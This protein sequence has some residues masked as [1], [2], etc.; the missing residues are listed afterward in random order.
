MSYTITTTLSEELY[1]FLVAEA[2]NLGST[3]KAILEAALKEYKKQKLKNDV[4]KGLKLRE[5][6]YKEMQNQFS[7]AQA[8]SLHL[9]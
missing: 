1:A 8:H 6:E 9:K 4:A 7:E 3:K 5:K 2:K